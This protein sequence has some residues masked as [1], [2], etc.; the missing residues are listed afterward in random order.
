[1]ISAYF[2]QRNPERLFL[3]RAFFHRIDAYE[4]LVSEVTVAEIEQVRD[5]ILKNEM[6]TLIGPFP[7]LRLTHISEQL[8]AEYVRSGAVPKS[9]PEDAY[10]L[11]L[12]VTGDVDLILSWNFRH[13]VRR[14]T[15]D[16]VRMIST[17]R[18]LRQVEIATPAELL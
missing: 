17:M 2:D 8:A 13:I 9:Y 18:G 12:A 4:V 10:H 1:V 6:L 11:A 16:I 3:T 5:L 14:K 15:K 7:V